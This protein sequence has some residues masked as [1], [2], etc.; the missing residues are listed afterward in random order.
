MLAIVAAPWQTRQARAASA[1]L[2]GTSSAVEQVMSRRHERHRQLGPGCSR[3]SAR[4]RWSEAF[5]W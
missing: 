4:W 1:P 2:Q 3:Y 5:P